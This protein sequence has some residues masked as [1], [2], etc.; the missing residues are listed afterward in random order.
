MSLNIEQ[1]KIIPQ[2]IKL[3]SKNVRYI[4]ICLEI[5]LRSSLGNYKKILFKI[6]EC[7]LIKLCCQS[8]LKILI[9]NVTSKDP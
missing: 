4:K 3:R 7:I 2:N 8:I 9:F 5:K 1:S 6:L